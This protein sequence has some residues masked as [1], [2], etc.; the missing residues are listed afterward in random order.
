MQSAGY[1][2]PACGDVDRSAGLHGCLQGTGGS[3]SSTS[4]GQRETYIK[5]SSF[6]ARSTL[7]AIRCRIPAAVF[8]TLLERANRRSQCICGV[9]VCLVP[10]H[11]LRAASVEHLVTRRPTGRT[12]CR[13]PVALSHER[14]QTSLVVV[15]APARFSSFPIDA[16]LRLRN[17]PGTCMPQEPGR[18]SYGFQNETSS[19]S[20][21]S[22]F[23]MY[24]A[25]AHRWPSG[26]QVGRAFGS[27]CSWAATIMLVAGA[28]TH[29]SCNPC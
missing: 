13:S 8:V 18:V 24:V 5:K 17:Q 29:Q 25:Y 7:T 28:L 15:A 9:G 16:H 10:L 26:N 12:G 1:V 11:L 23:A 27:D 21:L 3:G 6:S 19:N 14:V 4:L 2:R 20:I 22:W